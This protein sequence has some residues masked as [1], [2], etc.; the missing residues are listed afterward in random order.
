MHTFCSHT[1]PY[2]SNAQI[3]ELSLFSS[4]GAIS[5]FSI[6]SFISHASAFKMRLSIT[7]NSSFFWKCGFS[8]TVFDVAPSRISSFPRF[9]LSP[10]QRKK[11]TFP[12]SSTFT[13]TNLC[14]QHIILN[15]CQL[16]IGSHH[17]SHLPIPPHPSQCLLFCSFLSTTL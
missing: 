7:G 14:I 16:S 6:S 1:V 4:Y 11:I 9:L 8:S 15:F 17:S 10:P 13:L 2:Q 5:F 3:F 12:P